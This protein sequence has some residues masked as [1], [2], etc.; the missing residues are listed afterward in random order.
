M[1]PSGASG[2][3]SEAAPGPA[4]FKLRTPEPFLHVRRSKLRANAI[5]SQRWQILRSSP[6]GRPVGVESLSLIHI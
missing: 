1:H 2:I 4:Q 6:H 3:N 5:W